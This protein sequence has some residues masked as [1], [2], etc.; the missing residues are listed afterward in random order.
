L[1]PGVESPAPMVTIRGVVGIVLGFLLIVVGATLVVLVSVLGGIVVLVVGV[2][3][4]FWG[5][6]ASTNRATLGG[7]PAAVFGAGQNPIVVGLGLVLLVLG[8]VIMSVAAS[9]GDI[10]DTI[11]GGVL[12]M[13]GIMIPAW[14][15]RAARRKPL[16]AQVT[17]APFALSP[18]G[19]VPN[20]QS[21]AGPWPPGAEFGASPPPVVDPPY[22]PVPPTALPGVFPPDR[23]CPSCGMGCARAAVFCARCGKPLPA[24]PSGSPG[25][26]VSGVTGRSTGTG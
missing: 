11:V 5:F 8:L 26:P 6:A 22:P 3:V 25:G 17:S 18:S 1:R 21:V 19:S 23:Y 2:L 13:V 20:P 9:F 14:S 24:P 15:A 16:S 7:A 12:F 4:L 10:G